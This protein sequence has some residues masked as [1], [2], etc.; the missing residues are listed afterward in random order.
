MA[1]VDWAPDADLIPVDPS[2]HAPKSS[3][4]GSAESARLFAAITVTPEA[5]DFFQ[6]LRRIEA[7]H[8]DQPRLGETRRPSEDPIRIGQTP[9]MHFAPRPIAALEID[10]A[11]RKRLTTYFF[12]VFGPNGPLPLHLTEYAFSRLHH[13][14][15]ETLARFADIF[16]HRMASLFFRAWAA[17]EPA[18]AHDRP[19]YDQF[20][21]QL[22][23]VSGYG[24]P[25]LRNRDAM[26]DLLKLHFTGRLASRARNPEGLRA[27]LFSF[28]AAPVELHEFVPKW[29]QL[30]RDSLCQLGR[31]RGTG[32][33]GSTA[34]VGAR[35]RVWDH[36]FRI[37]MGPL[38]LA[39]FERLLPGGPGLA[40][41][42]PILRNYVGDEL[43]W[44]LNLV[45]HYSEVPAVQL[46]R[47]GRLGLTSWMGRRSPR[48]HAD[49][50]TIRPVAEQP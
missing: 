40:C 10:P 43:D 19:Q 15:D 23:A 4:L 24:M 3:D 12:G 21:M 49:E 1:D 38:R 13:H 30:P 32:T 50:L 22:A 36:R 34:T 33:L 41:L 27:I 47:A 14:G 46:G 8:P 5:F 26:P 44:E 25:P 31:D 45:L 39:Q 18:V 6:A 20:G 16:H 9:A 11:G 42:K 28:F 37:V 48:K 7:V 2:S 17:S 35:V 29:I